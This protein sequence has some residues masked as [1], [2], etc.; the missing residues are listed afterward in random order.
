MNAI[1]A[2]SLS[3]HIDF[4]IMQ[5]DEEHAVVRDLMFAVHAFNAQG[6]GGALQ[7]SFPLFTDPKMERRRV[8]G[9]C[10]RVT[11]PAD[12]LYVL[13]L[14][15]EIS[16]HLRG[17]RAMTLVRDRA[18]IEA[19]RFERF[20]LVEPTADRARPILLAGQSRLIEAAGNIGIAV[21]NEAVFV[22]RGESA[23]ATHGEVDLLGFSDTQTLSILR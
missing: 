17:G 23:R 8:M 20:N 21:R 6:R 1:A 12:R 3:D 13:T 7:I 16:R 14:R 15:Y 19:D 5:P 11:G 4:L 10:V 18:V 9:P 22:A 2:T